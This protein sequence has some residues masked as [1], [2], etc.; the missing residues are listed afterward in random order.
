MENGDQSRQQE[1]LQA[2]RHEFIKEGFS[3][4][5]LKA[6]ADNIGVTKAMIHY[7]FD[8]KDKLF[9]EV[10]RDASKKLMAGLMDRLEDTTPLFQKIEMFIDNAIDR[11]SEHASLAGFVINELDNHPEKTETIFREVRTYNSSVFDEQLEEAASEYK[12]APAKS[13]QVVANMLSLCMFPYM[14]QSFLKE[15]LGVG[16]DEQYEQF[17]AQRREVIKD[18]IIN[19]LAS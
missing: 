17:L 16:G 4:A 8:T 12:I 19:A 11:F 9:Q 1:I 15:V 10:Y 2:A 3:G 5:R 14:G 18:T 6:I 7:Y 13:G